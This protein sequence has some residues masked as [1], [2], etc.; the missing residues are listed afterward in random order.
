MAEPTR[1]AVVCDCDGQQDVLAWIDD[2]RPDAGVT[3][4]I[5]GA[6]TAFSKFGMILRGSVHPNSFRFGHEPCEDGLALHERDLDELVDAIVLLQRHIGFATIDMPPKTR[7][8][9]ETATSEQRI[10]VRLD[11]LCRVNGELT[12]TRPRHPATF[13][14]N[15]TT[16]L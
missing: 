15:V 5:T 10:V 14:K 13:P 12:R 11:V 9:G 16:S 4:G 3:L 1:Y 2:S 8:R 7:R 6:G